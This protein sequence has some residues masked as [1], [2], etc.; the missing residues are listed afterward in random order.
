MQWRGL[1][2]DGFRKLLH[3]LEIVGGIVD[4]FGDAEFP[5]PVQF[6]A[7]WSVKEG[8]WHGTSL[9]R[10]CRQLRAN[11][12]R[13]DEERADVAVVIAPEV[14][15]G[16]SIAGRAGDDEELGRPSGQVAKDRVLPVTGKHPATALQHCVTHLIDSRVVGKNRHGYTPFLR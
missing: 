9:L 6:F 7:K 13:L 1:K 3:F 2:L 5:A 15:K 14:R 4:H 16:A 11:H 10:R 12:T 8:G